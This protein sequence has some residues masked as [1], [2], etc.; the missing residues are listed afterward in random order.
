MPEPREPKPGPEVVSV[1]MWGIESAQDEAILE[2]RNLGPCV[3]IAIYEPESRTGY[4]A[5]IPNPELPDSR[6]GDLE[7]E[8]IGRFAESAEAFKRMRA[9]L[10][11]GKYLAG[12]EKAGQQARDWVVE[13]LILMGIPQ[14]AIQQMWTKDQYSAGMRLDCSQGICEVFYN[15]EEGKPHE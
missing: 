6:Y 1:P 14:D 5:H 3:G 10:A 13:G 9:W 4:L 15:S 11:G 8:L 2:T 7:A 12:Y